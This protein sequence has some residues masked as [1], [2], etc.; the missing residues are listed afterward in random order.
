MEHIQP[1]FFVLLSPW[2]GRVTKLMG[3]P[4]WLQ[5]LRRKILEQ[6]SNLTSIFFFKLGWIVPGESWIIFGKFG[7]YEWSNLTNISCLVLLFLVPSRK[8]LGAALAGHKRVF[9][10]GRAGGGCFCEQYLEGS[11]LFVWWQYLHLNIYDDDPY[12]L[13]GCDRQSR[14]ETAKFSSYWVLV[15]P[16]GVSNLPCGLFQSFWSL[17]FFDMRWS[18]TYLMLDGKRPTS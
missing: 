13:N 15:D 12:H 2:K 18:N 10:I 7:S 11:D 4:T 16:S 17:T 5:W 1:F 3:R 14:F 9:Q 8:R 6:W